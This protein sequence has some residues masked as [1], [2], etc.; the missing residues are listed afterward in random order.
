VVGSLIYGW[1]GSLIYCQHLILPIS[2]CLVGR[3]RCRLTDLGVASGEVAFEELDVHGPSKRFWYKIR[4]KISV[5]SAKFSHNRS[6]DERQT[7]V[8]RPAR[9]RLKG[10][11][12]MSSSRTCDQ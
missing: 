11:K 3:M 8:L 6:T 4:G 10:L 12:S 1:V 2:V 7:L 5:K 9:S